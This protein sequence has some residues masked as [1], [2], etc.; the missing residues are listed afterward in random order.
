MLL[1]AFL[2]ALSGLC[3]GEGIL[4]AGHL[5]GGVGG[6]VTFRT[7][8][9]PPQKPFLTV[10]WS[11]KGIKIITSTSTN[12]TAPEYARRIS[13]DRSTGALE[14]RSLVPDDSGEYSVTIT[15]DGEQQ[16]EGR[17]T[18][19][20]YEL[21]TKAV[22]HSPTLVLIEDQTF[23]NMSCEASGSIDTRVWTKDDRPLRADGRVSFSINN[24]TVYIQ[25]VHSSSHGNYKCQINNPVSSAT[26]A[27]NLTVNY[28]P[29]NVSI[30]GPSS[31]APGQRV[32]LRCTADSIPPALFTWTFNGNVT[33][34]NSTEYVIERLSLD[35][36]GN[37]TC[38]AFNPVTMWKN[39]TVLSLRACCSAPCWSLPLVLLGALTLRLVAA[40]G[41]A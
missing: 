38:S 25:P 3:R 13:L 29:H 7:S 18:L 12:V 41:E 26:A 23:T 37:Y 34:V 1:L 31:A 19:T 8:L 36:T 6:K 16:N 32:D 22:I 28:G 30:I 33:L 17:I 39:S 24:K 35:S 5:S 15:P 40:A 14:L 11:F 9:S 2:L 4:P 21:V 10:S 27:Y 20:V